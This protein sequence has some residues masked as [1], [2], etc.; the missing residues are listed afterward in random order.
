MELLEAKKEQLLK[1]KYDS[2][3]HALYGRRDAA[4][5]AARYA[6]AVDS[7]CALFGK[8]RSGYLFSAP[9][10]TEVGGNHTDHQH[11]RVLAAGVNLDVIAVV[12]PNN[13]GV[14]TIHSEGFDPDFVDSSDLTVHEDEKNHSQSLVRG[15]C[16]AFREKGFQYGGFDAYT[17]SNVL[18]GSGLS[19]SAAFEVL[20]GEI[21]TSFIMTIRLIP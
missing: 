11:G 14:I 17:I 15:M 12:S 9:G 20:V 6:A 5:H 21:L 3:F 2:V 4:G 7:F 8:G 18:K 16:A 10:R 13:T 1:G 19:S